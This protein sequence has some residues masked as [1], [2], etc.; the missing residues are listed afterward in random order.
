MPRLICVL[1]L[2][3]AVFASCSRRAAD[4]TPDGRVI[5]DYWEMWTGFEGEAMQ[6]IVD[7][8]NASQRKIFVR[9]LT[10]SS[11]EQKLM[12]AAVGG[13]PPDVAG[14]VS[15][16]LAVFAERNALLPLDGRFA[17]SGLREEDYLPNIFKLCQYRGFLWALPSTPASVA[18][19][20]DKQHFV[21]A[22]LD[23]QKPPQ[24]LQELDAMAE[25]LTIV[26]LRRGGRIERVRFPELTAEEKQSRQ[27]RIVQMGFLPKE[28]GW[29]DPLWGYWF[30]GSLWNGSDRITADSPENLRAAA[31]Y[32]SYA[33][34]YGVDNVRAF[35]ASF[36]NFASPQNPFLAGRLSMVQQGSW[37]FSYV[38]KFSPGL[39]W[40]NAP[41]PA[42]D[43][44]K[45]PVTIVESNL[46]VIPRAARHPDEGFIFLR[47][48]NRPENLEKLAILQRKFPPLKVVSADFFQ[49]HPNP[50]I[51]DYY[52]LAGSPGARAAPQLTLW[53]E[54]SEE[55]NVAFQGALA[56]S[57]SPDVA[58]GKVQRRMQWKLD[59]SIRR[60]DAVKEERL[61]QWR[62]EN[63]AAN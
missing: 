58:L 23:P 27:F 54:Y 17:A 42:W 28:P 57:V 63:E 59:R 18:L 3:G 29:W 43:G 12:L 56:E 11:V 15:S 13:N 40:G 52:L 1:A 7:D 45:E 39:Q 32:A 20:W 49:R 24:T 35:G 62:K 38:E 25:R 2:C 16:V 14:L 4:R 41:F 6:A 50:V 61:I 19:H 9:K 22:G 44:S 30:G 55:I 33:K 34:K 5:V 53:M 47:Y 10:V 60:W 36:G 26:E 46:L 21:E 48:V 51:R 8:F 37:M 31:W